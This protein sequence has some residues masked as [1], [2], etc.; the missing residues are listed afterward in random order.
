M[1]L[2]AEAGQLQ[3]N[4]MEPVIGSCIFE[5]QTLFMNAART[6]RVECID[7]ITA[8]ADVCK[9]FVEHSIGV[10]T[11]L[12]PWIGYDKSTELAAEAL[13]SG[14][15]VVDLVREK[16]LLTDEQITKVLD[17]MAMAGKLQIKRAAVR[18]AGR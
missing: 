10:V 5:S 13:L 9:R 18:G 12:N 4:V 1:S 7:G 6:L 2:A 11:A 14:R 16:K 8:N 15:G 3:L 17:P